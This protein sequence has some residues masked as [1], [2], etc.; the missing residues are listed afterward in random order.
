M[1]LAH[2]SLPVSSLP[3]STNFYLNVLKPLGYGIFMELED[4]VGFSPK[5]DAPDFW[6]HCHTREEDKEEGKVGKI[7]KGGK[8][9]G[10]KEKVVGKREGVH[11]AFKANT[12]RKVHEFHEAA[13]YVSLFS[14]L[15]PRGPSLGI[16]LNSNGVGSGFSTAPSWTITSMPLPPS[17]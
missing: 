10:E 14:P 5:Y 6:L 12:R 2:I 17:V 9:G 3:L 13:L 15:W 1:P 8:V 16:L 7:G 11:I 4:S